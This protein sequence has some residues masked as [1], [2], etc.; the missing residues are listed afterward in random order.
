M[1]RC[2][3][4][5]ARPRSWRAVGGDGQGQ[6]LVALDQRGHERPRLAPAR[7]LAHLAPQG[8]QCAGVDL[9][10]E[11]VLLERLSARIEHHDGRSDHEGKG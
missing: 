1:R 3:A 9:P 11:G 4:G 10:V 2:A 7:S 8:L 5:S 6:A